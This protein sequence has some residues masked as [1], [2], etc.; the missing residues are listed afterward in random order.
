MEL[1]DLLLFITS[2]FCFV[3]VTEGTSGPWTD[4][5]RHRE[6]PPFRAASVTLKEC[7][8]VEIDMTGWPFQLLLG[9]CTAL[10]L[11]TIIVSSGVPTRTSYE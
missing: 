8:K 9:A 6:T 5:C 1:Q 10:K 4:E 7:T 3:V 11:S 2:D